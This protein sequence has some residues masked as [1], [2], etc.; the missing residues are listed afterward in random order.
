[1]PRAASRQAMSPPAVLLLI[2]IS[3]VLSA[4]GAGAKSRVET[5]LRSSPGTNAKIV[6]RIPEGSAVKVSQCAHGWCQ[7][8]WQGKEG[9]ALAKDFIVAG[10]AGSATETDADNDESKDDSE[11][12][13]D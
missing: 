6:A 7:V 1:M 3:V 11:G 10:T 12:E 2:G 5:V 8:S 4:C 13:D 9:Y